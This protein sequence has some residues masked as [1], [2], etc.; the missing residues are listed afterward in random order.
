MPTSQ[1][2]KRLTTFTALGKLYILVQKLLDF[3]QIIPATSG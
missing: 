2:K 1:L 3:N